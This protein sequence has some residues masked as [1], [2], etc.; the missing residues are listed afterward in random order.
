MI[1]SPEHRPLLGLPAGRSGVHEGDFGF[2]ALLA[3]GF[4]K[5]SG[6]YRTYIQ[7]GSEADLR[8]HMLQAATPVLL[9]EGRAMERLQLEQERGQLQQMFSAAN[10]AAQRIA[11]QHSKARQQLAALQADSAA[12]VSSLQSETHDLRAENSKL[13]A[14]LSQ[15]EAK[16]NQNEAAAMARIESIVQRTRSTQDHSSQTPT[17]EAFQ[18]KPSNPLQQLLDLVPIASQ[19]HLQML[20]SDQTACRKNSN[21]RPF[22]W[23]KPVLDWCVGVWLVKQ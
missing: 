15:S 3:L 10:T 18:Q 4:R 19:E 12:A 11:E 22:R 6:A 1:Q 7:P 5:V 20:L 8:A 21:H 16:A 9:E 14:Q 2:K 23:S 13:R 17:N